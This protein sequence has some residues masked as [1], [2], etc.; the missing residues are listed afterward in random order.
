MYQNAGFKKGVGFD[1]SDAVLPPSVD[2][3]IRRK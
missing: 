1:L 3:K 2:R